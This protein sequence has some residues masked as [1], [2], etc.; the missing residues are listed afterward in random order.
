[1]AITRLEPLHTVDAGVL[2]VA[3]HQAG[4]A[5]GPPVLLMLE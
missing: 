5:D 1:M 3:Y 4:P 2:S